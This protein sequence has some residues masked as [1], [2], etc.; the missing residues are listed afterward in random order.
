MA[1]GQE[2]THL[3]TAGATN[4]GNRPVEKMGAEGIE[5]PTKKV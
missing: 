2:K 5:P 3:E 4:G 1:N